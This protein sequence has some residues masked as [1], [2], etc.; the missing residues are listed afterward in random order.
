LLKSAQGRLQFR[1]F[2]RK[3]CRAANHKFHQCSPLALLIGG[4][5][6]PSVNLNVIASNSEFATAVPNPETEEIH[7]ERTT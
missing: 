6:S 5:N 7:V 1:R 2:W 4:G 3:L